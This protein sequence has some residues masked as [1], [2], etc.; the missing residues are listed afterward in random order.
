MTDIRN[1]ILPIYVH[2]ECG[3]NDARSSF[4]GNG[5]I[6]N[7]HFITAYHVIA[8]N[9]NIRGQSN[10][11]II[12]RDAEFE[13][14][15]EKAHLGKSTPLD[16]EGHAIGHEDK[17]N[18]DFIAYKIEG[19]RSPLQLA[20]SYPKS[21]E[22][23]DCCF[24]HNVNPSTSIM[25]SPEETN[26]IYYWETKGT[27]MDADG[28]LGNFFGAI[29]TT[30]HPTDGGSSGSPLFKDNVVYGILHGGNPENKGKNHPEICVFYSA[31]DALKA[32]SQK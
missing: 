9:Q 5:F 26:R 30:S 25:D 4:I 32:I 27:V 21:G 31:Y 8:E 23:L 14:T 3:R 20:K 28:F 10:P 22:I 24:F 29:F 15:I 7:D 13:L 12:I 11:Y 2:L 17:N 1:Y 19:M 16:I 18:G 6:I